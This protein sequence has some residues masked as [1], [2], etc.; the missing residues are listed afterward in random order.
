M[1]RADSNNLK[2][3]GIDSERQQ[4]QEQPDVPGA[5]GTPDDASPEQAE[6]R[7]RK[8]LGKTEKHTSDDTPPAA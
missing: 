1:A 4:R 6:I 8:R 2:R 7:A 5:T 3:S